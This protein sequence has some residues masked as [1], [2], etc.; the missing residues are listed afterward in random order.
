MENEV[1]A[2]DV[3]DAIMFTDV[4]HFEETCMVVACVT[5]HNGHSVV[6]SHCTVDP[7]FFDLEDSAQKA[8]DSACEKVFALLDFQLKEVMYEE[9]FEEDDCEDFEEDDG[10][11]VSGSLEDVVV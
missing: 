1:T 9:A 6:G 8:F 11:F 4:H 7:E 5:L 10:D 3:E 2:E